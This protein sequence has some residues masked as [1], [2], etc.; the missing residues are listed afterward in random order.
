M[1][2]NNK[3]PMFPV[4]VYGSLKKG[5]GNH[6]VMD[7]VGAVF[8]HEA[9]TLLPKYTMFSL[10]GFPALDEARHD[11]IPAYVLG[12]LYLVSK[13]GLETLDRFENGYLR[14]SLPLQTPDNP[15]KAKPAMAYFLRGNSNRR[16]KPTDGV[17]VWEEGMSNEKLY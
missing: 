11:E 13:A 12:E 2:V 4:F 17:V 5:F 3:E 14:K 9:K 1:S 6:R 10:G 15:T 8:Q 16:I 7:Y